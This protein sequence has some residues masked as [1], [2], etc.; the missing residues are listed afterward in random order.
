M[1]RLEVEYNIL[2][3]QIKALTAQKEQ[4]R[5]VIQT[6]MDKQ[7]GHVPLKFVNPQTEGELNRIIY[8]KITLDGE[9]IKANVSTALWATIR[10]DVPDR[11]KWKAAVKLGKIDPELGV[12]RT[13]V[14]EIRPKAGKYIVSPIKAAGE[15]E[16][17]VRG[18]EKLENS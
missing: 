9:V 7:Y 3:Q 13:E 15:T 11:E 6:T 18:K 16:V 17:L 14:D 4:L 10:A 5:Q 2:D 1:D 8:D 12:T